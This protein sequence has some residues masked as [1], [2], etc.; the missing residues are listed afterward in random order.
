MLKDIIDKIQKEISE[1]GITLKLTKN[2]GETLKYILK[3]FLANS[4]NGNITNNGWSYIDDMQLI[5]DSV[6]IESSKV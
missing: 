4:K 6:D 3:S 5:I 2:E 1:D